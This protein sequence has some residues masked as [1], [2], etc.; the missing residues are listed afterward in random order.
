MPT[1]AE[2]DRARA[3]AAWGREVLPQ[4]P[5]MAVDGLKAH[6]GT[7]AGMLDLIPNALHAVTFG[8]GNA[9]RGA[10]GKEPLVYNSS[11]LQDTFIALTEGTPLPRY[12]WRASD[13]PVTVAPARTGGGGGGGR[14]AP[15]QTAPARD[16]G[17][18]FSGVDSPPAGFY[19]SA[20]ASTETPGATVSA[21]PAP[22]VV[23]PSAASPSAMQ[24]APAVAPPVTPIAFTPAIAPSVPVAPISNGAYV[25]GPGMSAMYFPGGSVSASELAPYAQARLDRLMSGAIGGTNQSAIAADQIRMRQIQDTPQWQANWQAAIS[26]GMTAAAATAFANSRTAM[27]SGNASVFARTTAAADQQAADTARGQAGSLAYLTGISELQDPFYNPAS[28][29]MPGGQVTGVARNPATG[30]TMLQFGTGAGQNS[31]WVELG[32]GRYSTVAP[33]LAQSGIGALFNSEDAQNANAAEQVANTIRLIQAASGAAGYDPAQ[34]Y[35]RAYQ[36]QL[37][38]ANARND[39]TAQAGDPTLLLQQ[40]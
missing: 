6:Y 9:L 3:Q 20:R 13:A 32:A 27:D 23:S 22:T 39:A 12:W 18:R 8:A 28:A 36:E 25:A 19:R 11:P 17:V 2:I 10:S 14:D 38:R 37:G 35:L 31:P 40:P 15:T 4:L 29:P 21:A 16:L 34:A 7:Q 30:N 1:Q 33:A 24:G 26:N 5:Q